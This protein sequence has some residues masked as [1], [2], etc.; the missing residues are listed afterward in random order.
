VRVLIG[1]ACRTLGDDDGARLEL[2]V[3]RE[4]FLRLGWERGCDTLEVRGRS[5]AVHRRLRA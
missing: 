4:V 2:D 1:L 5:R 3:A